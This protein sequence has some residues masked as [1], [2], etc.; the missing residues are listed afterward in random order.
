MKTGISTFIFAA[1]L[2]VYSVSSQAVVIVNTD[3]SSSYN[4]SALTGFSTTG[5]MMDGMAVTAYF[6]GGGSQTLYWADTGAVSGGVTGSGWG[7]SQ[8]GDTFGGDWTLSSSV[9]IA[10]IFIDA[11]VGN[12][13][14]DITW[15]TADGYGTPDSARGWTFD[16][17]ANFD[18]TATYSGIV[19]VGAAPAVGDLWRYLNIDFTQGFSGG[20]TFIADTD[21]LL[22]AGD[23]NPVPEPA[24]LA[25]LAIGL[26]GLGFARLR[27]G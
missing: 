4:T 26:L 19:S 13:V 22:Y 14:F 15:P 5:A 3:S 1:F 27:R 12:T 8:S 7:L 24:G 2:A 21:N 18:I 25:M 6:L 11:G 10:S 23:I 16:T 20:M 17:A 9:G